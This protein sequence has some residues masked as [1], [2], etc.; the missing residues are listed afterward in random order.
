MKKL[1][2]M[3]LVFRGGARCTVDTTKI[4]TKKDPHTNTY[5]LLKW[6]TPHDATRALHTI[7]LSE[8]A[9][10][11]AVYRDVAEHETEHETDR[12]E[13]SQREPSRRETDQHE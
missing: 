9:A 2:G 11:I 1:V 6:E 4:E 12:R 13:S 3:E 10:V 8:V 7:I 5:T